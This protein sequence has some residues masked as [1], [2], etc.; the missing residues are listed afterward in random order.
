MGFFELKRDEGGVLFAFM[1]DSENP[2][3]LL[4][5]KTLPEL[6][7]LLDEVETDHFAKA[8]V[9]L[10]AKEDNFVAGADV[11]LFDNISRPEEAAQVLNRLH[12]LFNRI[13]NLSYP[14]IAAI[15][16]PCLGGGLE[17]ALACHFRI[18]TDS[19]KTVLGLPEVKLGLFPAGGGTQRLTRLIGVRGALPLMLTGRTINAAQAKS[20]GIAD[21]VVFPH[22]LPGTVKR[23]VPFLRKR[24]PRKAAYPRAFTLDWLLRRV[25]PA[26]KLYFGMVQKQILKR[27]GG[28]YPA[29]FRLAE[30]VEIGIAGTISD[31]FRAEEDRFGPLALSPQS[32][33]LRKLFFIQTGLKKR[34][35]AAPA[36]K[37]DTIGVLGSGLMGSGIATVSVRNGYRVVLKDVARENLSAALGTIWRELDR[38]ARS[39]LKNPVERDRTH[40]LVV[41]VLDYAALSRCGLVIEA[42]FEDIDLKRRVVREAEEHISPECIFASNTSAI[43]ISRIA[44]AS[45]RPENVIG[46]HYFSP[47]PRMPL[48]EIVTTDKCADWVLAT[49]VSVGRGQGKTV[50]VVRDGPGFYTTRI[51][52]PFLFEAIALLGEG[53]AIEAVDDAVRGFGF[54]VGPFRL[55]DEIGIDVA[56]HVAGEME[57]FF[58]PRGLVLPPFLAEMAGMG[59]VGKKSGSGFYEYKNRFSDRLRPGRKAG[60]R[61]N[62]KIYDFWGGG[63]RKRIEIS[64][65]RKRLVFLLLNEAALC[66]QENTIASVEDG[67]IGAVL[68]LGF[69]PFLGGPFRYMD[70]SGP[71][72]VASE[73]EDFASRLGQRFQPAPLLAEMASK[74]EKFHRD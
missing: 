66:L 52:V 51:L 43:P 47:V 10:S 50:I 73:M 23:C 36:A 60:D 32:R 45:R 55:L 38:Q 33:M 63:D 11:R 70:R 26:R 40:S 22:D 6:E 41:P 14:S 19:P 65:I 21:L 57:E 15:N 69:P 42:V 72:A 56:A 13:A 7:A 1:N 5:E 9:F 29:P 24:F 12:A 17:L 2:V 16:G 67:D 46:M 25:P 4:S 3:N 71:A 30:C 35:G 39:R 64:E 31:G 8:L 58:A 20:L 18:A 28:H 27:T 62:A 68:G 34:R 61:A 54:P 74:G 37:I 53:V 44:Q 48:L 59:L 49:A